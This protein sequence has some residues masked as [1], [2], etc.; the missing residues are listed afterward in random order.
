MQRVGTGGVPAKQ[1]G[2]GRFCLTCAAWGVRQGRQ[3]QIRAEAK[4]NRMAGVD[5]KRT[6]ISNEKPRRSGVFCGRSCLLRGLLFSPASDPAHQAKPK[7]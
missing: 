6:F 2:S 5:P 7:A 1:A 4:A 3:I